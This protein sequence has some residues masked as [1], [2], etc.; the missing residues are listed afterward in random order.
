M[1]GRWYL[2]V[3]L[4]VVCCLLATLLQ[5]TAFWT[6]WAPPDVDALCT[7]VEEAL[8]SPR[9]YDRWERLYCNDTSHVMRPASQRPFKHF[10]LAT[11]SLGHDA[12]LRKLYDYACVGVS[13]YVI[14]V[15]SGAR[16]VGKSFGLAT[17]TR[18]W[19]KQGRTVFDINL[20]TFL[21]CSLRPH[22]WPADEL[23]ERFQREMHNTVRIHMAWAINR[24]EFTE[25]ELSVPA[26]CDPY[27]AALFDMSRLYTEGPPEF[28]PVFN[29]RGQRRTDLGGT[30]VSS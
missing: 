12:Y 11:E 7:S 18:R 10:T 13:W 8:R 29:L 30:C 6:W 27:I 22:I 23:Y 16:D 24:H 14:V 15:T 26:R 4:P 28:G 19:R 2:V 21:S 3:L 17:M 25:F 20:K 5:S 1:A 9:I